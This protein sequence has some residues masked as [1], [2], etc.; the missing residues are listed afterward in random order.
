MR[1]YSRRAAPPVSAES[2]PTQLGSV[3]ALELEEHAT[4]CEDVARKLGRLDGWVWID[5][6]QLD[7]E[8]QA[9][10]SLEHS[11]RPNSTIIAEEKEVERVGEK[12]LL[13]G[14]EYDAV[15]HIDVKDDEE[16]LPLGLNAGGE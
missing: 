6:A 3:T 2:A 4:A 10:A 9:D 7:A 14:T 16:A 5:R 11:A 8:A 1:V 15:L 13:D 12:V